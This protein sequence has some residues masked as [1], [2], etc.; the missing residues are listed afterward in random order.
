MSEKNS[1]S[2]EWEFHSEYTW[3]IWNVTFIL[4]LDDEGGRLIGFMGP[5]EPTRSDAYL[6]DQQYDGEE[7]NPE[8]VA[9]DSRA[10][11]MEL[12][13]FLRVKGFEG[14][15]SPEKVDEAS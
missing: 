7:V 6:V 5:E 9:D 4:R 15:P 1:Q 13:Q 11:L 2:D 8:D 10:L 14:D 12:G 3:S